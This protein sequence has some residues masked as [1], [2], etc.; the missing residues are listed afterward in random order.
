LMKW[1]GGKILRFLTENEFGVW[2]S[3]KKIMEKYC[4]LTLNFGLKEDNG[5]GKLGVERK[6]D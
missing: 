6:R 1:V 2:D 4:F 5:N 3:R